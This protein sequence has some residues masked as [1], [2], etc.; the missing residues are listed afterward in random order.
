M[1]KYTY[2]DITNELMCEETEGGEMKLG[3]KEGRSLI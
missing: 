1:P 3:Q 2:S